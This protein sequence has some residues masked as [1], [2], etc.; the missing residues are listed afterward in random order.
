MVMPL[1]VVGM[2]FG[3]SSSSGGSALSML[4]AGGGSSSVTTASAGSIKSALVNAEKNEAKQLEQTAK[5]PQVQRDL[6]RYEK[7]VKSA[8][9]L[10]DVLDDPVARRVFMTANGLKAFA[11]YTGM[12]KKVLASDPSDRSSQASRLASINGAWYDAVK[13]FNTAKFG[14]DRLSP[15]M[16]GMA[17]RWRI[18]LE[19]EGAPV[20]AMLEVKRV[21][22]AW[23]AQV[24]GVDVP[25]TVDGETIKLDLLWRDSLDELRT[26]TLTGTLDKGI[27]TGTLV[28]DGSTEASDWSAAPY[29][30]DA[31]D[32]VS[33]NY[34]AEKRLDMLDQ[35]LPGL[36]SAVLFKQVA[37][38]LE[39]AVDILGSPLGR[40]VITTALNIPKQIA[41]QSM[42]AQEKAINQRMNPAKLQD[43][44]FVDIIAQRYLLILNG[45][46]GGIT[47]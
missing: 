9:S 21:S 26:S 23:T 39:D 6:A 47:A 4:T 42:V 7:V 17:G 30:A 15:R 22:G 18:E 12:A 34:I 32:E 40:E 10:A 24:D 45:G 1:S 25:I 2:L 31:I 8:K 46:L 13:T 27:L 11:D 14:I 29:F 28:N 19:R 3:A 43:P 44:K 16:D 33:R 41:I 5:D 35:Q 20:E 37:S 38:T 36:G